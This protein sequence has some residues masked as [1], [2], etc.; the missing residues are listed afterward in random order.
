MGKLVT[1]RLRSLLQNALNKS[2]DPDDFNN[3]FYKEC[4]G[5]VE[6]YII[7]KHVFTTRRILGGLN[8]TNICLVPKKLNPQS[9]GDFAP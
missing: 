4:G 1:S 7:V 2:P 3:L 9:V 5:I 8:A 6:V